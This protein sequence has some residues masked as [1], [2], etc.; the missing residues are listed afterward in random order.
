MSVHTAYPSDTLSV[1]LGYLLKENDHQLG[2]KAISKGRRPSAKED[3][4]QP[5][6]TAID[7]GRRPL[8]K[9]DSPTHKKKKSQQHT[10]QQ[11]VAAMLPKP[12]QRRHLF[13]S[14]CGRQHLCMY[15]AAPATL[16]LN[17]GKGLLLMGRDC[18]LSTRRTRGFMCF[19]KGPAGVFS[20]LL[21]PPPPSRAIC[22]TDWASS[23]GVAGDLLL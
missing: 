19:Q 9:E 20:L 10:L 12:S 4:H 1:V 6:K 11:V 21:L 8:S 17:R 3:G 13:T 14:I 22:A 18:V 16:N 15:C 2:R 7:Q 5:R 23:R